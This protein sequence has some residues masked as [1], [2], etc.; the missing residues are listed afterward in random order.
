MPE[1]MP[2]VSP[3]LA[4][5]GST[6]DWQVRTELTRAASLKAG[7]DATEPDAKS[8]SRKA[9]GADAEPDAKSGLTKLGRRSPPAGSRES[10]TLKGEKC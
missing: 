2:G 5:D 9:V 6:V 8:G 10:P 4:L 7:A 1:K 3:A